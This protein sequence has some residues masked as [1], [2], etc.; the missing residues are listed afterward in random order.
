MTR[1]PLALVLNKYSFQSYSLT[2]R[3]ER[4]TKEVYSIKAVADP[5]GPILDIVIER[6][7]DENS[8]E[9]APS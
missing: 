6:Q 4:Q 7:P 9:I 8:L 5:D 1:M 3:T 2:G